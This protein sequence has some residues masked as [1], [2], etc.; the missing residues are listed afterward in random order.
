MLLREMID[1]KEVP[2]CMITRCFLH[3]SFRNLICSVNCTMQLVFLFV[4]GSC[5]SLLL[6]KHFFA[7][8]KQVVEMLFSFGCLSKTLFS[9]HVIH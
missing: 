2:N 7:L 9:T 4:F 8:R 6:L 1:Q 3:C 5:L